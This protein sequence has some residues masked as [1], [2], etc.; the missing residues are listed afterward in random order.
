MPRSALRSAR[1]RAPSARV[2]LSGMN[3]NLDDFSMASTGTSHSRP[4]RAN[5]RFR[6]EA[7]SVDM[8][9]KLSGESGST[10][11]PYRLICQAW[12][13]DLQLG[14]RRGERA[15]AA[16]RRGNRQN[17]NHR[18]SDNVDEIMGPCRRCARNHDNVQ[19]QAGDT[20]ISDGPER[21]CEQDRIGGVKARERDQA[22]EVVETDDRHRTGPQRFERVNVGIDARFQR[23]RAA[24]GEVDIDRSVDGRKEDGDKVGGKQRDAKRQNEA[25]QAGHLTN[26]QQRQWYERGLRLN[27]QIGR[28]ENGPEPRNGIDRADIGAAVKAEP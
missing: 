9:M 23:G 11:Y 27:R 26:Q 4:S 28:V 25:L 6:A 15:S 1:T 18:A 13:A 21:P 10:E 24:R 19:R 22:F 12:L 17:G 2:A 14:F 3:E 7:G 16:I 20:N 5:T 8:S